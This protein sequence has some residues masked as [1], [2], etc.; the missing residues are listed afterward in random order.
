MEDIGSPVESLEMHRESE[1][2]KSPYKIS[3]QSSGEAFEESQ[4]SETLEHMIEQQKYS[5]KDSS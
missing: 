4:F 2:E 1:K 3:Q 5:E